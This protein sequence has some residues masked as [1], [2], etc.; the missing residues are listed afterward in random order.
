[1]TATIRVA[2]AT[3]S[4]VGD[5]QGQ[6]NLAAANHNRILTAVLEAIP[7]DTDE[8]TQ[9]EIAHKIWDDWGSSESL[10]TVTDAEIAA[11]VRANVPAAKRADA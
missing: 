8:S 4:D 9:Y 6:E 2:P 11:Y 10:L 1:M 7:S 3:A 5:W